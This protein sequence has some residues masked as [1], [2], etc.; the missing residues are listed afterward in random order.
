MYINTTA[1]VYTHKSSEVLGL[2]FFATFG[3]DDLNKEYI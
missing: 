2:C 3:L 1:H